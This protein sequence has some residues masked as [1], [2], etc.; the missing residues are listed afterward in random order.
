MN[1][2]TPWGAFRMAAILFQNIFWLE[3]FMIGSNGDI[4]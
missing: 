4:V 1:A 2:A 3:I